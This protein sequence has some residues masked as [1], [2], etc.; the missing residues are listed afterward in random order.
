MD[1]LSIDLGT[2]STVAVLSAFDRAPRVIEVD[3]SVTMSSAV[4]AS[5]DGTLIVGQDAERSARLDPARFEPNPKRRIDEQ[6]LLLGTDVVPVPDALAAV[7]RRIAE[8]AERQ[9]SGKHPDQVRIAHPAGWGAPRVS[10][11]RDAASKAGL[12][13][14]PML[15]PEPVAAAAHYASLSSQPLRP[16]GALAVYDLGAGTFDCAVVGVTTGG[17]RVLAENGLPDLGSLDVDQALLVHVG[18]EVSHSDP[19]QWQRLLRPESVADRR[20]RRLLLKDVQ[21]AKETLSRHSQT[22]VPMPEPFGDVLVTRTELE[23]LVR[24]SLLRSAE[25]LGT[26]VREAGLVPEQLAGIYLVGGPSRMPLVATL[27]SEHLGVVPSSRDQ[28]ETV[29]AF[30]LQ[31]VPSAEEQQQRTRQVQPV[32]P[33]SQQLQQPRQGQPPNHPGSGPV[34]SGAGTAGPG[35]PTGPATMGAPGPYRGPAPP[36]PPQQTQPPAPQ[37]TAAPPATAT[38]GRQERRGRWRRSTVL[39]WIISG[40]ALVVV[41]AVLTTV[42]ITSGGGGNT[43]QAG[44]SKPLN[45]SGPGK[46][47]DKHGFTRCLRALAGNVPEIASCSSGISSM[48]RTSFHATAAVSCRI[49]TDGVSGRAVTYFQGLSYEDLKL[50]MQL[51]FSD[52]ESIEGQWQGSGYRGRYL[53]GGNSLVSILLFGLADK[54]ACAMLVTIGSDMSN[55]QLVRYFKQTIR[56]GAAT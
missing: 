7:L 49:V 13:N 22:D 11:L 16:G 45:C 39:P 47:R 1:I 6:S 29:V 10:V 24:P 37:P 2:S 3:G 35:G 26:T 48:K 4:F 31:H 8:E 53:A 33:P 38:S 46:H 32:A 14:D 17:F 18:R 43:V 42:I 52:G 25:L 41:A 56:P 51:M 54:P 9:L 40:G 28:P 20:M 36:A 30:G 19:A 27:I 55:E 12:G 21:A 44:S 15:I 23:A 5:E 34:P 50:G